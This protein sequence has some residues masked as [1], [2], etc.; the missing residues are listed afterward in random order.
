[1]SEPYTVS[2]PVRR[3]FTRFHKLEQAIKDLHPKI[4][5][6]EFLSLWA[7][8]DSLKQLLEWHEELLSKHFWSD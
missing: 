5:K 8:F 4:S 7:K 2:T 3:I 6:Y 1:M